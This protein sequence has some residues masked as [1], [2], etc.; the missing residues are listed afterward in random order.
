MPRH[1]L[2]MP[3]SFKHSV[4]L[5]RL[6]AFVTDCGLIAVFIIALSFALHLAG[7]EFYGLSKGHAHLA[8]LMMVTVP[9]ILM[10]AI[11][12]VVV[13]TSPG[14]AVWG[15]KVEPGG[16]S[17]IV[18][19]LTRNVVKFLPWEIAHAGIWLVPGTPFIDPPGAPSLA[20]WSMAMG[21]Q[22]G[23]AALI[24]FTGRGLHDRM[25]GAR[26]TTARESIS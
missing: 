10:F 13:G 15:L 21:L 11:S 7:M 12:E 20:L 19:A 17:A 24:I 3:A 8:T 23:Q 18:S 2:I 5:R 4:R 9:V 1:P 16:S 22:S 14:K 25:A 26:V 6:P